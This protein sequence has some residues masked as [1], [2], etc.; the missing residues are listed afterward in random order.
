[1]KITA[2]NFLLKLKQSGDRAETVAAV[3]GLEDRTKLSI[4]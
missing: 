3:A 2:G 1:M 4:R